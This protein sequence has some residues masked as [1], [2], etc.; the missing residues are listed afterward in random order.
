MTAFAA[1][2]DEVAVLEHAQVLHDGESRQRGK[3]S[4]EIA[5]GAGAVAKDVEH[6]A[7][8]RIRERAPH[9]VEIGLPPRHAHM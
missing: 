8:E 5:G 7:A 6:F 1:V 3:P 4:R 9:R 2:D